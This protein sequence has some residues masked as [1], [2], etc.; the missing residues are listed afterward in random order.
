MLESINFTWDLNEKQWDDNFQKLKE[1]Y[2]REG[3]TNVNI[4]V[5]ILGNWVK[6]QRKAYQ[7]N[8]LSTKR[9]ELLETIDFKWSTRRNK[10]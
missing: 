3:H 5:E 10:N 7:K 6:V 2:F 1:F 9:K 4:N 8:K